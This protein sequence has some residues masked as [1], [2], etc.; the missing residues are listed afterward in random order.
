MSRKLN[1][2]GI[3]ISKDKTMSKHHVKVHKWVHGNMEVIEHLV[4]S[5]E[6]ALALVQK[7]H[8]DKP[9][10][11]TNQV[12]K[13]YNEQGELVHSSENGPADSYA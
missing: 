4:E 11:V 2:F 5:L 7:H 1:V 9:A 13:V 8:E 10:E 12:V 6:Q 3:S